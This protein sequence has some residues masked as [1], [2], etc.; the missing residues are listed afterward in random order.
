MG[1]AIKL[2]ENMLSFQLLSQFQFSAVAADL[3]ITLVIC[4]VLGA[5]LYGMGQT[6]RSS[7]SFPLS[8]PVNQSGVNSQ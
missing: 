3:L 4:I 5:F 7:L 8:K 2:Q 6:N 1:S